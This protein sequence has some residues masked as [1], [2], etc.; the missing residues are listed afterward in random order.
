MRTSQRAQSEY[1]SK[2]SNLSRL[3]SKK[4][5]EWIDLHPYRSEKELVK[6]AVSLVNRY[7]EAS[8]ELSCE[9]YEKIARSQDIKIKTAEAEEVPDYG[10]IAKAIYGTLKESKERVPDT[11]ERLVKQV[12][13]DTTLRNAKRDGAYFAWVPRGD[14]CKFCMVMAAFG[15]QKAGN[16]TINGNHATHI[17]AHCDCQY[18]VDFKG[19]MSINGYNPDVLRNRIEY[20]FGFQSLE[21]LMNIH[22]NEIKKVVNAYGK[23]LRESERILENESI[24]WERKLG[25]AEK[26]YIKKALQ[27]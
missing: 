3:A 8:A 24:A 22:D 11:V 19:N 25:E 5:K 23:R 16:N 9:M 17:H 27:G 15:W 18:M 6:K 12:G 26:K 14:S 2:L 10:E 21:E 4:M 7:G 1:V 13:S 20:M